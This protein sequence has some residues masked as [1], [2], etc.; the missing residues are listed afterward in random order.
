MRF[1]YICEGKGETLVF[2]HSYL[3]DKNMWTPQM[4]FLKKNYQCISIDLPGH[5]ESDILDNEKDISLKDL[6]K[7]ITEFL[8]SIG[9]EKYTYIGLS[10]GGMLAPYMYEFHRA[11]IKKVVIMDSYTGAEP[12][13]TKELYFSMLDAIYSMKK[14]PEPMAE[15]IAPIFFSPVVSKER[16]ELYNKFYNSLLN[17]S[18]E[19]IN[20]IVKM[21]KIIF[22]REDATELL[23]KIDVPVIF[24]T[25]EYDI[26]RPF[27]EAKEMSE[28]VKNSK[29]Y[30]VENAGHI[31]NL[32]NPDRVNKIFEE[33]L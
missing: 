14:I 24:I 7:D 19:K 6:A 30:L 25:G 32:E 3:W 27:S 26:P 23:K 28:C 22:G 13:A 10:V 2:I 11:K 16:T 8:D 17:I 21:G 31:S 18:S 33:I 29:I 4:E 1:S 12:E 5:G 20:T 15:K 9:V